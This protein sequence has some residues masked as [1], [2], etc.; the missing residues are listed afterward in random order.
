M[1]AARRPSPPGALPLAVWAPSRLREP[2]DGSLRALGASARKLGSGSRARSHLV[3]PQFGI[4]E[5]LRSTVPFGARP[6]VP[7]GGV[8]LWL[9]SRKQ[10]ETTVASLCRIQRPSTKGTPSAPGESA[11]ALARQPR[12]EP[13]PKPVSG[14][15]WNIRPDAAR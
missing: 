2:M 5:A 9:E 6:P 15:G 4:D 7:Q 8:S 3:L 1:G 13:S 12:T 14:A 11:P 10:V